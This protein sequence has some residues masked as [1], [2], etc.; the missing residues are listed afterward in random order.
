M[1]RSFFY[2]C[3]ISAILFACLSAFAPV[4]NNS[5]V[6]EVF[7]QTNQFRK[8][9]GLS[10][11]EMRDELNAIAQQHSADMASGRVAFGHGG[12]AQRNAKANS[13]IQSLRGFAENVAYGA[14][15]ATE[16]VTMWKNSAGHRRNMMGNYRYIG[17]GVATDKQGQIYYTE[18]FGG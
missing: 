18:V 8:S 12:F 7:S 13:A 1:Q 4:N 6:K 16:V 14:T 3:F 11:L 2:T 10:P 9:K 17:I 15:S 5:L